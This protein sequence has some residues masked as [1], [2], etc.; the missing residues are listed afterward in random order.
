MSQTTFCS[1][2]HVPKK[3]FSD[4]D[5]KPLTISAVCYGLPFHYR[6]AWV[7]VVWK[8]Y[9]GWF[10]KDHIFKVFISL[11]LGRTNTIRH[12]SHYPQSHLGI[13]A[14]VAPWQE[15]WFLSTRLGRVALSS[16]AFPYRHRRCTF[17]TWNSRARSAQGAGRAPETI[18]SKR[19]QKKVYG[20]YASEDSWYR[21]VYCVGDIIVLRF[22]KKR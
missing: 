10:S 15:F 14:L 18:Q 13:V 2:H 20:Q 6:T 21:G 4:S 22:P 1:H 9:R 17:T 16:F 5:D 7:R 19:Y 3:R 12:T 8:L 11:R